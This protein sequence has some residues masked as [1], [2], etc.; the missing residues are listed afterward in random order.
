MGSRD[1]MGY[2]ENLTE[3]EAS[4][5]LKKLMPR[6]ELWIQDWKTLMVAKPLLD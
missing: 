3:E 6:V 2:N 1:N 5:D 4:N